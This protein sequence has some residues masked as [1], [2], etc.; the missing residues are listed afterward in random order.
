MEINP[1]LQKLGKEIMV[2]MRGKY[3]LDEIGNGNDELCFYD[4]KNPV[5]TIR[6]FDDHYDFISGDQLISASGVEKLDSIKAMIHDKKE[7]NRNSFPRETAILSDCGHRCDLCVHYTGA[8]FT[9]QFRMEIGGRIGRAYSSEP[10]EMKK[11][12]NMQDFYRDFHPCGGCDKGGIGGKK[13]CDQMKCA[14]E[15]GA[16]LCRNCAEF[17]C[18]KSHAGLPPEIHTRKIYADDVTWGILPFVF[19]QYGN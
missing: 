3:V 1:S 9:E 17:P 5:L 14:R 6:I 18:D 15:K 12:D 2:F 7:P 11:Y 13:D 16:A 19:E 4:D 10:K 8:G